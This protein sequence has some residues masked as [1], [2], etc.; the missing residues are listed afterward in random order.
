MLL[1]FMYKFPREEGTQMVDAK[2][3]CTNNG[4]KT[5]CLGLKNKLSAIYRAGLS[6]KSTACQPYLC[7]KN[8]IL[9]QV[10]TNK[11]LVHIL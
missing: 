7:Y 4:A 9:L 6:F 10:F 2:T 3:S 8:H 1:I 5:F 11:I